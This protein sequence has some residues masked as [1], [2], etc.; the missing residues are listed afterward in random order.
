MLDSRLTFLAHFGYVRERASKVSRA[1]GRLMPNLCGP[2][3]HKRRLYANVVASSVL[4]G[5]PIW[6]AALDVTRKGK[7]ILRDIQRG[8]AQ[9]VCSAYQTVSLDAA[10]LLAR[11]PPYVLVASMRRS[12]QE[13]IWDLREAGPIPAEVVRDIRQEESLLMH[14]QWFLYLRREDVA[15]VCTCDA[16]MPHVDAWMSRSH[17]GLH[18]HMVQI[19]TGHECFATYLHRIGKLEDK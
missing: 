7:Q 3:E 5:A 6:S 14:Q 9:R 16:I 15:G 19:L 12:I 8:I 11:S 13:R 2:T 10:L 1:L 17:G 4:Y 18:I